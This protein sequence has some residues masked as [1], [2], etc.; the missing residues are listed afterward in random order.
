MIPVPRGGIIRRHSGISRR[1]KKFQE[2]TI[3]ITAR[4]RDYVASMAGGMELSWG[5]FFRE[6]GKQPS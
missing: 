1:G 2:S 3:L 4:L 6:D 5:G